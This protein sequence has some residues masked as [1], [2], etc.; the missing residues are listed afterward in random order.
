MIRNCSSLLN[1]KF[2]FTKGVLNEAAEP[3]IRRQRSN[4]FQSESGTL[5]SIRSKFWNL[6]WDHQETIRRTAGSLAVVQG[7][8]F[9]TS[10]QTED[11]AGVCFGPGNLFFSGCA[12]KA[13][14][15]G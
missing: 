1:S 5:V 2:S 8:D 12:E 7:Y 4:V 9:N 15:R 6:N 11:G 14:G 10:I 13:V 3:L